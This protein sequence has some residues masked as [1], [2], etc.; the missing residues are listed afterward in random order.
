MNKEN[1]LI[2]QIEDYSY[3]IWES[4][5]KDI[6][7]G[8][9]KLHK[10]PYFPK[11][12]AGMSTISVE[13]SDSDSE[14]PS[15]RM[16]TFFDLAYCLG[17]QSVGASGF[18]F[19]MKANNKS[20]KESLEGFAV[21]GQEKTIEVDKKKLT[22]MPKEL[23]STELLGCVSTDRGLL[24][25]IDIKG[26]YRDVKDKDWTLPAFHITIGN[27]TNEKNIK[28][29][30]RNDTKTK[31][32]KSKSVRLFSLAN[33]DESRLYGVD[34]NAIE[35]NVI[36]LDS[37]C[38]VKFAP[39]Y[40][41]CFALS[42]GSLKVV[43]NGGVLA[44]SDKVDI[45]D[46][47]LLEISG[48]GLALLVESDSG[49]SKTKI[50]PMSDIVST[51]VISSAI[52]RSGEVVPF[53]NFNEFISKGLKEVSREVSS[54]DEGS[55][56]FA[57]SFGREE[58]TVLQFTIKGLKQAIPRSEEV[59]SF[60]FKP[61]RPIEGLPSI[62]LGVVDHDG[63]IL[64]VIDPA[65]CFGFYTD[66]PFE[67]M[68]LIKKGNFKAFIVTENK[69]SGV[70]IESVNQ[71][72][73]PVSMEKDYIYGCYVDGDSI[74][75]IL[76]MEAL[77]VDFDEEEFKEYFGVFAKDMVVEPQVE[78]SP[79]E[80][81]VATPEVGD[82]DEFD[83]SLNLEQT[84]DLPVAATSEA[85][86]V[87]E[88]IDATVFEGVEVSNDNHVTEEDTSKPDIKVEFEKYKKN[89]EETD[90]VPASDKKSEADYIEYE[91]EGEDI[92]DEMPSDEQPLE[93]LP[94]NVHS[95]T[96]GIDIDDNKEKSKTVK[97]K[98]PLILLGVFFVS[99]ILLMFI[100]GIDSEE[101]KVKVVEKAVVPV[102]NIDVSE[103]KEEVTPPIV[104][105]IPLKEDLRWPDGS[106]FIEINPFKE[107]VSISKIKKGDVMPEG[108]EIY[109]V[110]EGDTL[111]HIARRLTGNPFNYPKLA[112]SSEIKN[113]DLIYPEQKIYVRV[114]G[115]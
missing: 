96:S 27:N 71:K 55:S 13:S 100:F 6:I 44:G 98:E 87:V 107:E 25:V 77:L 101:P 78:T 61:P 102:N 39:P 65:V 84:E 33:I 89:L 108:V 76:N 88:K 34:S 48:T 40:V 45:E 66:S 47:E 70:V 60:D 83:E 49:I 99:M 110:V 16:G 41:E 79:I 90:K 105:E 73:V 74:G 28:D 17:H 93:E 64:P 35:E 9:Q 52:V 43:L 92:K 2:F 21:P 31:N 1:L 8:A 19:T 69:P 67:K 50:N 81:S 26:L 20:G 7:S 75:L 86:E 57:K 54:Y 58:T 24:P 30:N 3:G 29:K 59:D 95:F 22:A 53:L 111:W 104:E 42:S 94:S 115:S 10:L 103:L 85:E 5:I 36:K 11:R 109:V 68:I 113:P 91:E 82:E 18:L 72:S 38:R 37:I 114:I 51:S 46:G 4:D 12:V 97:N 62:V 32:K 23:K 56:D 15:S 63:E 106:I 14:G 80:V 112:E